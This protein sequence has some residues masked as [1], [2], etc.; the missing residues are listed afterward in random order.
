VAVFTRRIRATLDRALLGE[1]ALSLQEELH[2]LA[3]AE[4]AAGPGVTRH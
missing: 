1:T 3:A 2:A 4:L